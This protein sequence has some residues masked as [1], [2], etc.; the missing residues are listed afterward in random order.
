MHQCSKTQTLNTHVPIHKFINFFIY[1][2]LTCHYIHL[3]Y[4]HLMSTQNQLKKH[5]DSNF[6][7]NVLI[8]T[9]IN[10]SIY[11]KTPLA[12]H[13]SYQYSSNSHIE[14]TKKT[15]FS[16]G[17]HQNREYRNCKRVT[18]IAMTSGSKLVTNLV[19]SGQ[20]FLTRRRKLLA[21]QVMNF[22][23]SPLFSF[24]NETSSSFSGCEREGFFEDPSF[25]TGLKK[26]FMAQCLSLT[27]HSQLSVVSFSI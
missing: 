24:D 18:C 20:L 13:S 16:K 23:G 27:L 1:K 11:K 25:S 10:F 12:I 3:I 19:N 2:T 8:H 17:V 22:D 4:I 21:F 6:K 5:K 14:S 9:F 7:Y 26:R 15:L